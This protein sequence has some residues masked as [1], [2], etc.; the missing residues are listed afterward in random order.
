VERIAIAR[1][2]LERLSRHAQ[3]LVTTHDVELQQY[4]A[5]NFDL[6]H[7]QESPD[8]EGFFDYRMRSG[9]AVERNA[10]RLLGR[11]G[12]PADVVARALA[13]AG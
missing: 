4:L 7:F 3:V 10:I 6:Y 13:L 2:V 11:V 5:G 9:A 8:I 12:F 1:A